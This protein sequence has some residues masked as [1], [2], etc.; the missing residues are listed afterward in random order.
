MHDGHLEYLVAVIKVLKICVFITDFETHP[1]MR[2]TLTFPCGSRRLSQKS[3]TY[4]PNEKE[5]FVLL[6]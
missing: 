4:E 1:E 3:P 5:A 2:P 6:H